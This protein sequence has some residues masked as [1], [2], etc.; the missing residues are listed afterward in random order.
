MKLTTRQDIEAP[1]DFVFAQ[2]TDFDQFER[3]ALHRGAEVERLDQLDQPGPGMGWRLA[4]PLRG[5]RRTITLRLAHLTPGAS[6]GYTLESP[7]FTGD[8]R[9][10]VIALAPK[11]T[12]LSAS[13]WQPS[14]SEAGKGQGWLAR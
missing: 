3:M 8:S 2:L 14:I 7:M 11:R 10:E 13:V 9:I 1:L 5:K 4:F 6:I 12:R